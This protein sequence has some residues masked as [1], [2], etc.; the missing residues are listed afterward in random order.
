[1][2]FQK[3]LSKGEFIVLAEMDTP[4]GVDISDLITNARRVNHII[5]NQNPATGIPI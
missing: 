2:S 5:S 1:M 4:K 3:L